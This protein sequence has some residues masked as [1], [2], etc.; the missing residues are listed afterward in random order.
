MPV[1]IAYIK[2]YPSWDFSGL[3]N[4]FSISLSDCFDYLQ[5]S[6]SG[7]YLPN[8]SKD[9]LTSDVLTII[10]FQKLRKISADWVQFNTQSLKQQ[11]Q[12]HLLEKSFEKKK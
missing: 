9:F 6:C 12:H 5:M 10:I 8:M 4:N 11:M 1:C 2:V 7:K 3:S